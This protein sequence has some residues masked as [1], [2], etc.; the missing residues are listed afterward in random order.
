VRVKALKPPF[1]TTARELTVFRL[2]K[3]VDT[4]WDS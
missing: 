2:A 4:G 1:R 3:E